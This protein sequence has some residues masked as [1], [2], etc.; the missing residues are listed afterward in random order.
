MPLNVG[1]TVEGADGLRRAIRHAEGDLKNLRALHR[2]VA[3][4]VLPFVRYATPRMTGGLFSSTRAGA[5]AKA[6][7]IRAG[8]A[9]IPYAG[10][11]HYGHPRTA[12]KALPWM[13][14]AI[15]DSEKYWSGTYFTGI[16]KIIS[17]NGLDFS[18][19]Q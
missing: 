1:I 13:I 6:A 16:G 17:Q 3:D 12:Q 15:H 2:T 5:T 4:E 18:W 7:L 10:V 14:D 19:K 9:K 11:T 8:S